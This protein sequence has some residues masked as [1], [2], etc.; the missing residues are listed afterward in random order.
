MLQEKKIV[1]AED[2]PELKFELSKFLAS[3][4]F[5]VYGVQNICEFKK[6]VEIHIPDIALIDKN[7]GFDNGFDLIYHI[8]KTEEIKNIPIIIITGDIELDNRLQA[9]QL[10]A[11][12][13]L[14]KPFNLEE[15]ALRLRANL[16]RS[17]S[18]QVDEQIVEY[19]DIRVN[20]RSHEVFINKN[21]IHLTNIEYKI[22]VE[23]ISQKNEVVRRDRIV[24]R[25]LSSQNSSKR[26]L[27]VHIN[28]LRK[29]LGPESKK[30]K[31][32]RGMGY[33]FKTS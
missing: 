5:F 18:Y 22:F 6:C 25:I 20:L 11:D 30:I 3:Q 14:V 17:G 2:D 24:A 1:L 31:T 23:L 16:R 28:S 10:G 19:E 13:F 29:K 4:S 33:L 7:L 15:L 27:D 32:I 8:R 12:D 26:T 9:F 21:Q